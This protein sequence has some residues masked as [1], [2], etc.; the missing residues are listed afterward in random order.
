MTEYRHLNL[1]EEHNRDIYHYL[2]GAV[3]PRPI[4]LTCTKD[5]DGNINLA[6]FSY[7]NVFASNPP[8]LVIG[9]N[10]SGRSGIMKDTGL[11]ATEHKQLT[12]SLVNYDM[13]EQMNLTSAPFPR[14]IN[15]FERSGLTPV[16]SESVDVPYVGES[17]V[18]F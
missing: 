7:F 12:I 17:P 18:A 6:P 8:T 9:P 15:E 16:G 2:T 1:A 5:K 10:R 4:A 14:G 11:N 13:V 3:G